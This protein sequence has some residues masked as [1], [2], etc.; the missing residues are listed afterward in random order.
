[1]PAPTMRTLEF[2]VAVV[3]GVDEEDIVEVAGMGTS[4]AG[5]EIE[6]RI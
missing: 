3:L 2:V 5:S 1:M 4:C 6:P